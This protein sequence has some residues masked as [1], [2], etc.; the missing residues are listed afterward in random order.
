MPAAQKRRGA[1]KRQH[2][3][4][5]FHNFGVDLIKQRVL[6]RISGENHPSNGT[7]P[8]GRKRRGNRQNGGVDLPPAE[9]A[10]N[11]PGQGGVMTQHKNRL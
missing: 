2:G 11:Q 1:A 6:R 3:K 4:S 8:Q 10:G 7:L 5:A 9:G